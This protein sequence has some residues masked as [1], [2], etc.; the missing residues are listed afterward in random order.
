MLHRTEPWTR[1][2]AIILVA[3]VCMNSA[4]IM[5][6]KVDYV[7]NA[8][9][10]TMQVRVNNE[11]EGSTVD[12]DGNLFLDVSQGVSVAIDL[13]SKMDGEYMTMIGTTKELCSAEDTGMDPVVPLLNDELQKFGNLSFNCPFQ[14][15]YYRV[16]RFRMSDDHMLVKMV[17]PGEYI[18]KM[19]L[20]HQQPNATDKNP[21]F[22][23]SFYFEIS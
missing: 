5:I 21:V 15:G 14:K 17:P 22:K 4:K 18:V 7:S 12:V 19:D 16:R 10:L 2:C 8:D 20:Q 23:L 3:F 11:T 1:A 6:T 9:Y 13:D